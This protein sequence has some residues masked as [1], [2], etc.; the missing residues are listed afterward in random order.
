MTVTES[1]CYRGYQI[2]SRRHWSQWCVSVYPLRSDLPILS[3]STLLS[4]MPRKD[5]AIDVARRSI[6]RLLA[7]GA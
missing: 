2:V 5:E 6:D 7:T 4:L 1:C 3:R